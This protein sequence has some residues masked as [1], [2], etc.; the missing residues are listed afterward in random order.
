MS[1]KVL[2]TGSS[3][4][5][6][7]HVLDQLLAAGYEVVGTVRSDEKAEPIRKELAKEHPNGKYQFEIVA[8]IAAPNAF[9]AVFQKH[10]DLKYVLHTASPFSFGL[11]KSNEENYLIPATHGTKSVLESIQKYGKNVE[12][13][14]VTSSF[15]AIVN[16]DRSGDA[17]FINDEK[18][19]NPITWEEAH[20]DAALSYT[21]SKKLAE[22]LA[23]DFI[24]ENNST[25]KLT[26]VNPPYVFGPQKYSFGLARASLNTS[27][28]FVNKALKTT[29]DYKG[30]F[31][32]P[33]GVSCDVR[34]VA[35][36]H[37]LPLGKEEYHGQRL[38][39]ING[40]GYGY[41][42]YEDGKFNFERI[43]RTLQETHPEL[44]GKISPG[45]IKDNEAE[46]AK[47]TY[48]KNKITTDLTKL[49][50]YT[51]SDTIHDAAKQILDFEASQK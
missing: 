25:F 8:D 4:F 31:A 49:K 41:E 34:D 11:T 33:A 6:A 36:L 32:Q 43:L 18:T 38:F 20:N 14:V 37:V 10:T 21:A 45:G 46:L 39:P 1:A 51:F 17:S 16:R 27:A 48:Y 40:T 3:G 24:K 7:L 26:T 22:K 19:W 35:K 29:T 9:D 15:A 2:L 23:W 13:V 28:D 12:H 47:L 42:E 44:K 30:P 50:F 5:I